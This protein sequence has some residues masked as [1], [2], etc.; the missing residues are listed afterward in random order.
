MK[1]VFIE[2]LGWYGAAAIIVAYALSSFSVIE[3]HD[4]FYQFMNVTGALGIII[5]SF[6]KKAYQPAA[7][8]IVWLVIA[9]IAII[10]SL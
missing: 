2:L 5:V 1:N 3:T 7:L 10:K 4:A 8:N 9:A 6:K